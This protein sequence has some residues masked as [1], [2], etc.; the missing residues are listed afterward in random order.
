MGA[1]VFKDPNSRPPDWARYAMY[2]G[3]AGVY[4]QT[5]AVLLLR[6]LNKMLGTVSR[7]IG[8]L[9]TYL[10]FIVTLVYAL[11]P[12]ITPGEMGNAGVLGMLYMTTAVLVFKA[13]PVALEEAQD[14]EHIKDKVEMF[15]KYKE[16]M[17]VAGAVL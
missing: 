5:F 14:M 11:S 1:T 13:V 2:G 3:M 8:L 7:S 16:T 6:D 12:D 9:I 4:L 15:Q 17:N 10:G